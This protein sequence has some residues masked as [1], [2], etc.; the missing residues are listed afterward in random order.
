M[1]RIAGG[2]VVLLA[3]ACGDVQSL[4]TPQPLLMAGKR[5]LYQRV[6]ASPGT[7]LLKEPGSAADAGQPVTPFTTF[8]V[9]GRRE[10]A[11]QEWLEIGPDSHGKVAG[12]APSRQLIP[13]NQALTV[14]F[15]DP[16]SGER[17]LL[18]RDRDSL[19]RL[20]DQ[21]DL[22]S[23]ERYYD[24]AIRGDPSADSPIVAIQPG[25]RID[26]EKDF[27]LV[28]IKH[29]EDLYLQDRPAR[30]LEVASV[31]L[32]AGGQGEGAAARPFRTGIVFV[33][34]ATQSMRPYIERTRAVTR[35]VYEAIT[36]AGLGGQVS[37]GLTA[38]RDH[39]A[40]PT[41]ER[42]LARNFATLDTGTD[43]RRFFQQV[44]ALRASDV[45]NAEFVEDAFA[46]IKDAI[47]GQPLLG[48]RCPLHRA[49]DR[50]ERARGRRSAVQHWPRP[51]RDPAVG[52]RSR[53]CAVGHAP[54]DA[55]GGD[56]PPEGRATVPG[57]VRLSGDRRAL[58]WGRD[59]VGGGVRTRPPYPG[60]S[61]RRPS[62]ERGEARL[63]GPVRGA[64]WACPP[65]IPS[66]TS[67]GSSA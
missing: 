65:T 43:A 6:L 19:K 51:R 29:H 5:S 39:L 13:W 20:I 50:C 62:P 61:D 63:V 67:R 54:E 56:G 66:N 47:E 53:H 37:F 57:A 30:L 64:C 31:P 15:K 46:G 3:L 42:F 41:G 7:R 14:T 40:A 44:A 49:R 32:D 48:F 34:D 59:G 9:Y 21:N 16:A 55:H 28:P 4:P 26:I 38:F 27:Y 35:R 24:E 8:Y 18:F 12:F 45:T 23:Y 36:G 22:E 60:H 1:P 33:V 52:A 10:A 2:L 25:T 17:V 11:G 58:L